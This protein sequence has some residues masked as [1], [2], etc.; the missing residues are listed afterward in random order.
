M[1]NSQLPVTPSGVLSFT[2]RKREYNPSLFSRS[3]WARRWL[4]LSAE[5]GK[6]TIAHSATG[7]PKVRFAVQGSSARL[8]D[9]FVCVQCC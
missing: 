3:P 9:V 8:L 7:K 2:A 4:A 5:A 1:A 6:V